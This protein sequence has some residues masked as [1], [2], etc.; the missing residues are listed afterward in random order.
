MAMDF[1]AEARTTYAAANAGT[2]YWMLQRPVLG[3]GFLNT[4]QNSLT[5]KAYGE[6]DGVRG[7]DYTYGWIQ[8]RGLEAVVTHAEFFGA[9]LPPLAEKLDTAGRRL[10]A[11]LAALHKPDGHAYF[12][13]DRDMQAVYADQSNLVRH[14]EKPALIYTYS[15]A[16]VAKGL[17][18]AASRYGLPDIADH[19]AYFDRVIAAI[20]TGRFQMD[21]RRPL[22][23][24][25]LAAQADDFGPRMI[26]LGAAGMLKRFGHTAHLAFA[27]R[28]IAHVIDRHYDA[29]SGLLRNVPGEDACNVGH[30]IEFVG[31]ALDYLD[32]TADPAL[33]DKLERILVSSFDKGFVGPGITLTV[34]IETGD[35]QS[36]Y[37]PWW[38]LPET[39]RSAALAHERTGS[40]ASLGVW[41]TAH[42]AFF[43]RYWRGTPPIAYQ[44]MTKDGPVD[45][46]PATPD[47]DPGYH[48]GLSLLAAI[49][50]ADR[51]KPQTRTVSG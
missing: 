25:S 45:F 28:F 40:A 8:G 48:T 29:A 47:L 37:C 33:I 14:Q 13:Y 5:L 39:I 17:V 42:A 7:P 36:P 9:E 32:D 6:E 46:V 38:S 21:E 1:F 44:T 16:F 35:A 30:G 50:A 15:D 18:A 31:F 41:K 51:L 49:H 20:E 24:D 19:L 11:L 4:K 2:L 27:D 3:G 26:L 10:Y 22:S 34:S 43:E 23:L 12:C